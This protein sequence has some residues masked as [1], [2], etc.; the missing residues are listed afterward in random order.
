[1]PLIY[2]APCI[3][4][5]MRA[6][7]L[8]GEVGGGFLGPVKWHRADG[9]VPFGAQKTREFQGLMVGGRGREGGKVL[10]YSTARKPDTLYIIQYSLVEIQICEGY[11]L[12]IRTDKG[13]TL[14][15]INMM[16]TEI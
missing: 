14:T 9:R 2:T 6:Y 3:M 8:R 5:W 7:P 1:M 4:F 16:I 15:S 13:P 12:H 11:T 10:S